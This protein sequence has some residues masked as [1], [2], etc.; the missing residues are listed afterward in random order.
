MSNS[1]RRMG[2]VAVG[3]FVLCTI[4]LASGNPFQ[5]YCS[6]NSMYPDFHTTY[7]FYLHDLNLNGLQNYILSKH[8]RGRFNIMST[9]ILICTFLHIYTEDWLLYYKIARR[10]YICK[11]FHTNITGT[12]SSHTHKILWWLYSKETQKFLNYIY[13]KYFH[14]NIFSSHKTVRT[15]HNCILKETSEISQEWQTIFQGVTQMEYTHGQLHAPISLVKKRFTK[16]VSSNMFVVLACACLRMREVM[17][18][19]VALC[20]CA[21]ARTQGRHA[22]FYFFIVKSYILLE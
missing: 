6:S 14:T 17:R 13:C 5:P 9:F 22:F 21:N 20:C 4:A 1:T 10:T 16:Y 8:V 11:Y 19:V 15:L 3:V 2:L 18:L 12:F 7:T